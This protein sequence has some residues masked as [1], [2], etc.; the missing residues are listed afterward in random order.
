[1]RTWI[2]GLCLGIALPSAAA[3]VPRLRDKAPRGNNG[4]APPQGNDWPVSSS[5]V[6]SAGQ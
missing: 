1:M 3:P 4:K 6:P 2:V 5:V